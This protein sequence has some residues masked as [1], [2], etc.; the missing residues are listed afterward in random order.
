MGIWQMLG[1]AIAGCVRQWWNGLFVVCLILGLEARGAGVTNS[2]YVGNGGG[3]TNIPAARVTGLGSAALV[4]TNNFD[5][6]GAAAAATNNFGNT[7]AVNLT[8]AANQFTG[9][10]TNGTYYGNGVGLTN[11]SGTGG[12]TNT[13]A[14]NNGFGTNITLVT[15]ITNSISYTTNTSIIIVTGG[16][17]SH[18]N[19]NYVTN[20]SALICTFTNTDNTFNTKIFYDETYSDWIIR[21]D[22]VSDIFYI[23]NSVPIGTWMKGSIYS[24]PTSSYPITTNISVSTNINFG[25]SNG[26]T[27]TGSFVGD[28]SGLTNIQA[29]A[30]TNLPAYQPPTT[31]LS[32]L[33]VSPLT[34]AALF[35]PA[36][37]I[38][39]NLVVTPLTNASVFQPASTTLT[40]LSSSAGTAAYSNSTAFDL[41]G[42]G[43]AAAQL[44]TNN[45]GNSV[46]VTM[47]NAANQFTGAFT[48]NGSGLTNLNATNVV[49]TL[50]NNT[51]GNATTASGGW[52]T[53]WAPSSIT[54]GN[55]PSTVTNTAPIAASQLPGG[56]L[57]NN[58][59]GVTVSGTFTNGT[60]Y[61]NGFGLTNLQ[62]TNIV[63][64]VAGSGIAT[65]NG[66]GTNL[67]VYGTLTSTNL[68]ALYDTNNAGIAAALAATNTASILRTNSTLN[69]ALLSG[70]VPQYPTVQVATNAPFTGAVLT[71]PDGTNRAW[72]APSS[73]ITTLVATNVAAPSVSGSTGFVPTNYV[74]TL[75]NMA[76]T[77]S[78]LL[79][80]TAVTS[81]GSNPF[82]W[83]NTTG[84]SIF[85][86][87][88]RAGV[89]S[90]TTFYLNG[91]AIF[92]S[93]TYA[94]ITLPLQPNE[95]IEMTPSSSSTMYW[96]PY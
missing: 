76:T 81:T 46:T 41:A 12:N 19:G 87:L 55:L 27:F 39:S 84:K 43:T 2:V 59:T 30:I 56:V 93:G 82:Y 6:N 58:E 7:V 73:G 79:A 63:G 49:G 25:P 34:N 64:L 11:V 21:D 75:A 38:L 8:N 36:T 42:A 28:G 57:T 96:K 14:N 60:Y 23:T 16:G 22:Y 80:P 45:F 53:T 37:A 10:F 92:S 13:I 91:T 17:R 71:S 70:S 32:N 85:V 5:T 62:S 95:Y 90:P 18:A 9:T 1:A 54:A 86:F 68:N 15:V 61:G 20:Y 74:T 48:G 51:T 29:S 26:G 3:L 83:T 67:T 88:Y 65:S 44:A 89:G 31:I 33:V 52:P 40:N 24:P 78:N 47:T 35:Q 69:A 50:T 4:S 77:T 94:E 72:V 66:V